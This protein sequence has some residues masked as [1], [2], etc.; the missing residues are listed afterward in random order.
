ME[1]NGHIRHLHLDLDQAADAPFHLGK[2]W[3]Q[4]I[5]TVGQ[6]VNTI[7]LLP[8]GHPIGFINRLPTVMELSVNGRCDQ[9]LLQYPPPLQA[10]LDVPG[11]YMVKVGGT[12]IKV[13]R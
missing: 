9:L 4:G 8:Q 12:V 13:I 11:V 6:I 10:Q 1:Q 2:G 3:I 5:Q 7:Q